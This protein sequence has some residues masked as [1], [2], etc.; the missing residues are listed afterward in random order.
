MAKTPN[1]TEAGDLV[2]TKFA[3]KSIVDGKLTIAFGNGE[4]REIALDDIPTELHPDLAMHGLSQKIGDSYA[5][6]KGDYTYAIAQT[7]RLIEQLKN[8]E[9]RASRGTGESKPKTGE[10]AAAVARFKNV[11]IEVATQALESKT[12]EEKKLIRNNA[13]IKLIIQQMRLEKAQKAADAAGDELD[14]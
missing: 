5:S 9:M 8:G 2:K 13:N 14:I 6:A 12:D 1:I 4:V 11:S 10:L 7:E 3:E